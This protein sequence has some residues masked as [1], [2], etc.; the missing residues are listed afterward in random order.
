MKVRDVLKGMDELL[1]DEKHFTTRAMARDAKGTPVAPMDKSAVAFDIIGAM[2]RVTGDPMMKRG[3]KRNDNLA[4]MTLTYS[5]L[6]NVAV[7]SK[8]ACGLAQFCDS[9]GFKAVKELIAD[10]LK[11]AK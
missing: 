4:V 5:A 10:T 2:A 1:A 9:R 3:E 11:V 6:L 7:K 8:K